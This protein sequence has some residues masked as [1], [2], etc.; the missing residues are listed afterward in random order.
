VAFRSDAAV[1]RQRAKRF[2][3]WACRPISERFMAD[4]SNMFYTFLANT[5][6]Y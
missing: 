1:G 5:Q 4:A 3:D 6:W 2:A